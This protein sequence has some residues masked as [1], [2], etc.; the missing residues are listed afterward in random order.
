MEKFVSIPGRSLFS[1][2][3]S[4]MQVSFFPLSPY[5]HFYNS[6]L[7]HKDMKMYG[8]FDECA[9]VYFYLTRKRPLPLPPTTSSKCHLC[10]EAFFYS[11]K[12]T[13]ETYMFPYVSIRLCIILFY[14]H[15]FIYCVHQTESYSR[16]WIMSHSPCIHNGIWKQFVK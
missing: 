15:S 3:P 12:Q 10:W 6:L 4:V 16:G 9:C 2:P 11:V 13:T 1:P 14:N 5:L 8:R 7:F